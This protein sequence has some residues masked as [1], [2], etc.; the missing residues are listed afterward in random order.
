MTCTA[1][2]HYW[3]FGCSDVN[4]P[5]LFFWQ[6]FR[7]IHENGSIRA[8]GA[9]FDPRIDPVIFRRI[10]WPFAPCPLSCR[11]FLHYTGASAQVLIFLFLLSSSFLSFSSFSS[12]SLCCFIV[13]SLAVLLILP[14]P[15][16]AC[17][18]FFRCSFFS[19]R[20]LSIG[21]FCPLCAGRK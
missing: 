11:V 3:R 9:A 13:L 7:R 14:F 17:I 19:F 5:R 21:F 12:L 2:S 8:L 10:C 20:L 1:K 6:Y 18:S 16:S 15:L 4:H